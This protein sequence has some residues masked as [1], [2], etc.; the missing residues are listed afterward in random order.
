MEMDIQVQGRAKPLNEGDGTALHP[1]LTP[2][3]SRTP[4]LRGKEGTEKGSKGVAGECCVVGTSVAK[5][6]GEGEDPLA[7]GHFRQHAVHEM[8]G[9]VGHAPA[10][11]RRAEATPFAREGD[12]AIESTVI[13]AK[14]QEAVGEDSAFE[15]G[16]EFFL[17]EVGQRALALPRPREE[18]LEM[19]A[20]D[21]VQSGVFRASPFVAPLRREPSVK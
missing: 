10:A 13:A 14:P 8:R 1:S 11:A 15:V 2:P 17:D 9:G 4:S 16:A 5:R 3:I 12:E 21:R 18:R 7:D 19:L 6:V 20:N